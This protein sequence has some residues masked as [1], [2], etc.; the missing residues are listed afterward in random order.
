MLSKI[1]GKNKQ[2]DKEKELTELIS[3][4]SKMNL[5]DMRTYVNGKITGLEV[6]KQGLN[7]VLK[8]ITLKDEKSGKRYIEIDDDATKIKKGF[9]L[10]ILISESKKIS[11]S[12]VEYI[13]KFI[14]AY[15]TLIIDYDNKNSQIYASKLKDALE[16]SVAR[17]NAIS[18]V[19]EKMKVLR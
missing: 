4:I 3:R 8:K 18:S 15:S 13:Q 16:R 6:N 9:D 10:V 11:A 7:E 5:S 1:M 14:E 19:K 2:E 17:V 12:T